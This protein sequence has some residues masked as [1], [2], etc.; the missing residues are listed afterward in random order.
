MVTIFNIVCQ[1]ENKI[2]LA[3]YILML[4]DT[5][6]SSNQKYYIL[7]GFIILKF[8]LEYALVHPAYDLQRDEFLH[9]DQANHLAWGYTSIP[10]FTSWI[11][12]VIR[13]FGNSIFWVKFFPALFGALTTILVWKIVQILKGGVFALVLALIALTFSAVTRLNTLFQPNSF[14]VLSWT[15]MYFLLLKYISTGAARWLWL[16]GAGFAIGFLNKYNIVFLLLGTLPALMLTGQHRLVLK[17][18]FYVAILI[19]FLMIIPNLYWQYQHD[20]PVFRHMEELKRTQLVHVERTGFLKEQLLYFIGSIYVLIGGLLAALLYK[21]FRQYR[22][23]FFSFVFTIALFLYFHAKGYYAIGLYPVLLAFGAVYLEQA[24]R[25]NWRVYLRP[26]LL[27]VPLLMFI[28]MAKLA[29]PIYA[30]ETL[31][32]IALE[33]GRTHRWEDGKERMLEQ[34]Y[35]DMLGW[36]ELAKKVDSVYASL[37]DKRGLIVFCDNYGQAGAI[38]FYKK[39]EGYR[40]M[41]F[42]ADYINWY[43]SRPVATI[44]R[45]KEYH[46]D[47]TRLQNEHRLFKQV[48]LADR[49]ENK[50]AREYRTEIYIL[51]EPTTDIQAFLDDERADLLKPDGLQR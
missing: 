17:S 6:L 51:K 50:Y 23:V 38:N 28:P 30:P 10:P 7:F 44:I 48:L 47:P 35:A 20:F 29:F 43:V 16:L 36:K 5:Q 24:T 12:W 18:K 49:M 45:I 25:K 41:S 37:P 1:M 40:A 33:T 11:S 42:N 31:A 13:A 27:L 9:L 15:L 3:R 22:F 4:L 34:D 32:Q 14:D 26:L 39:N 46:D 2:K 8:V 19:A 21:P